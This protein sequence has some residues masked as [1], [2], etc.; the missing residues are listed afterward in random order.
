M[1]EHQIDDDDSA[2]ARRMSRLAQDGTAEPVSRD[3]VI[4]R[5]RGQRGIYPFSWNFIVP[6]QLTTSRIGNLTRLIHTLL[7]TMT[8]REIVGGGVRLFFR[9]VDCQ[10]GVCNAPCF[11]YLFVCLSFGL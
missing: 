8:I 7:K 2:W 9:V 3:K 4:R 10:L 6:V 1:S 11:D 5:E